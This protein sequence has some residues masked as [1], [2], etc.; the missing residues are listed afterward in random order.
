[1]T[2]TE[3]QEFQKIARGAIAHPLDAL[4]GLLVSRCGKET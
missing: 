3:F 1:M 4:V 2:M